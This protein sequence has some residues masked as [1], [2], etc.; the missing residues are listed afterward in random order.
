MVSKTPSNPNYS[1]S[2][3]VCVIER[4]S[5]ISQLLIWMFPQNTAGV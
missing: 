1:D 5:T 2:E 4:R 3:Y